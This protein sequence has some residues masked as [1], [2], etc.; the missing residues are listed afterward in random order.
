[1]YISR[2]VW[3]DPSL[4]NKGWGPR[5]RAQFWDSCKPGDSSFNPGLRSAALSV[6]S[7]AINLKTHFWSER[8]S[9]ASETNTNLLSWKLWKKIRLPCCPKQTMNPRRYPHSQLVKPEM[10]LSTA[11]PMRSG[12][13]RASQALSRERG[14]G[15]GVGDLFLPLH[16]ECRE[17]GAP[18]HPSH[19][20]PLF[21][22]NPCITH[23]RVLCVIL[24]VCTWKI[25]KEQDSNKCL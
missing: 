18:Y 8:L 6:V 22:R 10:G 4:R 13:P 25:S 17:K 24:Q 7:F 5:G 2:L 20:L 16:S 3:Q 23:S 11:L 14:A 12:S 9:L 19:L 1:M 15:M 21:P